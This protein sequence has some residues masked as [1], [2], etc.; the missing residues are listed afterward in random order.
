MKMIPVFHVTD[1]K[2]SFDFYKNILGFELKYSDES[3]EDPVIDLTNDF[4]EIQLSTIDGTSRAVVNVIVNDVDSLFEIFIKRGLDTSRKRESPVHQGPVNQT[5]GRREF[6]VT[7]R[8]G[9]TLRFGR[10][11]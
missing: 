4:A 11:L 3:I 7:D 8:D 5:W 1:M 6:Y 2:Q 10:P 9:H